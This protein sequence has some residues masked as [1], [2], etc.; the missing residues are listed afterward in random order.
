MAV[1]EFSPFSFY[2]TPHILKGEGT[3][4]AVYYICTLV[5]LLPSR[6]CEAVLFSSFTIIIHKHLVSTGD[7][8]TDLYWFTGHFTKIVLRLEDTPGS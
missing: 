8:T 7:I 4:S 3:E 6:I 2:Q 1:I 5:D